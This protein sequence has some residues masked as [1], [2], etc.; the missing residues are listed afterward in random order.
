MEGI[1]EVSN[2]AG[3]PA[4]IM[5]YERVIITTILFLV[6]LPFVA[7]L[8]I[9]VLMVVPDLWR[10]TRV[11]LDYYGLLLAY[12]YGSGTLFAILI[13]LLTGLWRVWAGRTTFL[14]PLLATFAAWIA[15]LLINPLLP[16]RAYGIFPPSEFAV[17]VLPSALVASVICWLVGRKLWL[18]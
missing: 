7:S 15:T 11:T 17:Y 4:T 1:G 10:S 9:F 13:G 8:A 16:L 5:R 12:C 2:A 6:L 14:T 3:A 18:L